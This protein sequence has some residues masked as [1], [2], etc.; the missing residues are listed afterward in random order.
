MPTQTLPLDIVGANGFGRYPKISTERTWNMIVSDNALV[1]FPG[2]R[3]RTALAREGEA[4]ALY[5]SPNFNHMIV[6]IDDIVFVVSTD[7]ARNQIG[8]LHTSS[9][10][11]FI[12]ENNKKEIAIVDGEK[13]Y[14]YNYGTETFTV[15]NVTFKPIYITFQDGY[16]IAPA[17]DTNSWILS[18]PNDALTWTEL[19]STTGEFQSKAG[20]VVQAVTTVNRTLFVI[21]KQVSEMWFD[22]G[23]QLFPYQRSNSISIPYGCLSTN[24]ISSGYGLLVWLGENENAGPALLVS[25]GGPPSQI[26][27][28]G[29]NFVLNHLTAPQDS[30]GFLFKMDGHVFYVLTF[31]TDNLSFVYDFNVNKFYSISDINLDYFPARNITFFNQ[32]FYFISL[33]DA[34]LYELNSDFFD[35]NFAVIPRVR[36]CKNIRLPTASRFRIPNV[37]ITLEQGDVTTIQRVDLSISK[38]GGQSFDYTVSKQLNALGVRPNRLNFWSLGSANDAVFQFR[39]WSEG[40]FAIIGG[41]T[42][43]QI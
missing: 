36:A 29:M 30:F 8:Q 32:N 11:V 22:T 37:N 39:F 25:D 23:T 15:V 1:P 10:S 34:S 31:K 21:G 18:G 4:R 26:S 9:G 43:V 38:D 14:V 7:L 17:G 40:R 35:Y 33:D 5:T 6:V 2:Y 24:T 20:D 13:I 19:P 12:S 16:L 41:Q 27:D 42:Q 28:E 3:F